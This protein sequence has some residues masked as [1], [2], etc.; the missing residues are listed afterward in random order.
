MERASEPLSQRVR[1]ALMKGVKAGDDG[2]RDATCPDVA[3]GAGGLSPAGWSG[4]GIAGKRGLNRRGR[5]LPGF[6][7]GLRRVFH[8]LGGSEG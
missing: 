1:M 3:K 2:A 5:V 4:C 6:A 8:S 7:R